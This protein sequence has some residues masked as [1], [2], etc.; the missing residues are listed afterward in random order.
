M[1]IS[2]NEA[3]MNTKKYISL[4]FLLM[5]LLSSC[6]NDYEKAVQ[7]FKKGNRTKAMEY[8]NKVDIESSEFDNAKALVYRIRAI[9]ARLNLTKD[10]INFNIALTHYKNNAYGKAF[11]YLNM[12]RSLNTSSPTYS[13][14]V[15]KSIYYEKA[16]ELKP[17][18]QK[19][20]DEQIDQFRRERK[21]IAKEKERKKNR[22]RIEKIL[23]HLIREINSF[24][25]SRY[26]TINSITDIQI[27]IVL[28]GAY[29]KIIDKY[30]IETNSKIKKKL[31]IFEYYVKQHRLKTLP[32]LRRDYG[33]ILNKLLW[34]NDITVKALGSGNKYLQLTGHIF[35]SNRGI[36]QGQ[37]SLKDTPTL[38][39]FKQVRYK[40]FSGAG[41]Y[42]Y[43]KLDTPSDAAPYD[44][45]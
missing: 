31:S 18:I 41:E 12:I 1:Q 29:Q 28:L 11:H 7:F 43:Y 44:F 40:W 8:L 13:K 34:E 9:D 20:N 5:I 45:E 25:T 36:K 4:F 39:R 32:K 33:Q 21:R 17:E 6:S 27:G 30:S 37:E 26:E 3:F 2:N 14:Y 19:K 23:E 15:T 35:A 24:K 38:L 10:S 42:T 16:N 22:E